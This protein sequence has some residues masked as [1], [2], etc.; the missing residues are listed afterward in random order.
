MQKKYNKRISEDLGWFIL[1]TIELVLFLL[2][3][4][5]LIFSTEKF[6]YLDLERNLP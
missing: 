5:R 2:I 6:L 4:N 3:E 1:L